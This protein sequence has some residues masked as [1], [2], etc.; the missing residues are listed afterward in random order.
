MAK[1][2]KWH[3]TMIAKLGEEGFNQWLRE[4]NRKGGY[5]SHGGLKN[6]SK[7]KLAEIQAKA[8]ARRIELGQI[9]KAKEPE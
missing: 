7:E 8:R 5:A 2:T 6:V 3:K 9:K 1:D 4:R